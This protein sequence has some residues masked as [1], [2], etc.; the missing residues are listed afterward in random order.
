[1]GLW[2]SM[3]EL[4]GGIRRPQATNATQP[5]GDGRWHIR[6]T[7][8]GTPEQIA[9]RNASGRAAQ[10]AYLEKHATAQKELEDERRAWDS[11]PESEKLFC[12]DCGRDTGRKLIYGLVNHHEPG[13]AYGGCS[14]LVGRSPEFRCLSCECE[15]GVIEHNGEM[16][17]FQPSKP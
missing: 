4:L 7:P 14:I 1:M 3:K 11:V 8:Q 10:E 15:W 16:V 2:S 6:P 9:A 12:P 13:R 5:V 17:I